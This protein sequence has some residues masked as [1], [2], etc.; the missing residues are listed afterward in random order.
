MANHLPQI[1]LV[2]HGETPWS[3][4]GQHTGRTDIPLT[5]RGEENA[6]RLAKRLASATFAEVWTSPLQRAKS[7][8]TLCGFAAPRLEPD[9]MEWD[10]G[11]YEGRTS[12]EIRK[13]RPSWNLFR[14]GCPQGETSADVGARADRVIA[15]LRAAGNDALLFAH[16]HSLRVLAAR[17]LDLPPAEARLFVLTTASLSILS[18]E[19]NLAEP[20]IRLWNDARHLTD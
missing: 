13:E 19:H 7:T 10:Y 8:C 3:L 11:A 2:R 20:T 12:A 6:R 5:P 4:T 1:Y 17:W 9:L 16:G 14:D 18:Y 15:R